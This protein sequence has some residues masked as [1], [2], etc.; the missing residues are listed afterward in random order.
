MP[1]PKPQQPSDRVSIRLPKKLR[2]ELWLLAVADKREVESDYL[3]KVLSDHVD[4][5]RKAGKLP[6]GEQLDLGGSGAGGAQ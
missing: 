2:G 5:C 1:R 4:E 6:F 3:R